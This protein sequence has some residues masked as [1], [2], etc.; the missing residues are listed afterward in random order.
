M[1]KAAGK[2]VAKFRMWNVMDEAAILSGENRPLEED[3]LVDTGAVTTVVPERLA[4]ALNLS[5]DAS[6]VL[7]VLADGRKEYREVTYGLRLELIGRNAECRAIIEP[8]RE[9]V[10]IGRLVLME[11]DV[12]V[13]HE[14]RKLVPRNPSGPVYEIFGYFG[15]AKVLPVLDSYS[16]RR[17][18]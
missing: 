15:G 14:Q 4:R 16:A 11:L 1:E 5:R 13:D 9:S 3:C 12:L 8:E 18:S 17:S 7:V 6:K 10:L 2:V